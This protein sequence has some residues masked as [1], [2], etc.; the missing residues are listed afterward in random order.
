V[1]VMQLDVFLGSGVTLRE[2]EPGLWSALAPE[3]EEQPYDRM[4]ASYDR[5]IGN[6]LYQRIA[7]GNDPANDLAFAREAATSGTG[8][9]LDAGCGSLLFTNRA[10]R[11][12][13]RPTLLLDLSLG[14]LQRAKARLVDGAGQL[15]PHVT[16]LQADLLATPLQPEAF[17]TV[18]CPGILHLFERPEALLARLAAATRANGRLF[19]SALVT[20]RAF[21]RAYLRTLARS[22]EVGCQLSLD[23]LVELAH[24]ATGRRFEGRACGNMASVWSVAA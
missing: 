12:S 16:L 14:M 13:A 4:A 15:P 18:L 7:W 23:A 24:R 6:R 8:P 10:H 22:G 21:G 20:D 19:V 2:L 3:A 5:L 9:L 11:E 17:E 1:F